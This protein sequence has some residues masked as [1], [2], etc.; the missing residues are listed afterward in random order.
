MIDL[1]ASF[2][3]K[4]IDI[5]LGP[6]SP[7]SRCR[8]FFSD[9]E[10][11]LRVCIPAHLPGSQSFGTYEAGTLSGHSDSATMAKKALVSATVTTV[12]CRTNE[13]AG[14]SQSPESTKFNNI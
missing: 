3:N 7:S 8:C 6:L 14:D 10:S 2:Q 11:N 9:V 5:F 4:K 13:T 1:F 12:H